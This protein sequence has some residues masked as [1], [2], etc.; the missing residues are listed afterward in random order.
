[1]KDFV[2]SE[3]SFYSDKI[4]YVGNRYAG[5]RG[6]ESEP[7][8]EL[9]IMH[10][11]ETEIMKKSADFVCE[12]GG[13]I[14]EVGFGMGISAG[15]IQDAG[16]KTHTI[17]EIHPQIAVKAREWAADKK[18]VTIIEGDWLEVLSTLKHSGAPRKFDGVFFDPYGFWSGWTALP[19][20][21]EPHCK[22]T[23]RISHFNICKSEKSSC[24]FDGHP[25]FSVTFEKVNVNPPENDYYNDKFYYIPKVL[26]NE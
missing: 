25:D 13:D 12:L 20:M 14:L 2:D 26:K 17:I 9:V 15:F 6:L 22:P 21:I 16:A 7:K 1:M 8:E 19:K 11:W 18:G 24:G 3:I 10:D 23:T 4:T 5:I